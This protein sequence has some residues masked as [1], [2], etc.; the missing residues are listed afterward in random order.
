LFSK[1]C[2]Q[3]SNFLGF[4]PL[5]HA[6]NSAGIIRYPAYQF[7]MV[8]LGIG[9][10]GVEVNGLFDTAL[11]PISSL[12]TTISQ[13]KTI[14]AGE[15]IGYSRKGKMKNSGKI[16]TIAIGYADGY[17]RRFSNGK[18]YVLIQGQK[19]PIIGNVCMD[20]CMVDIT[21]I[22]TKEGDEVLIYGPGISLKDLATQIGTI[23]YELLTNIS[24]RVKRV[25]YLD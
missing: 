5:R 18:G 9:L 11:R 20:M 13:I 14:E 16:A 24:S 12:K 17:D 2:S 19:A 7:D 1:M 4:M 23:P 22:D 21:G 8:R 3:V 15:T 6:L 25:Y 10:Y